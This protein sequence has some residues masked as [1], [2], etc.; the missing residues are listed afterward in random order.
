MT[1][2]RADTPRTAAG[3]EL[4]ASIEERNAFLRSPSEIR[5]VILAIEAEAA[6]EPAA[7]EPPRRRYG[8][9][10]WAATHEPAVDDFGNQYLARRAAQPP[11]GSLPDGVSERHTYIDPQIGPAYERHEYAGGSLTATEPLAAAI[12]RMLGRK[13]G[14]DQRF[15]S[16]DLAGLVRPHDLAD[17]ILQ[18]W[19]PSPPE[20]P[21]AKG[22][23]EI[24]HAIHDDSPRGVTPALDVASVARAVLD[25]FPNA[26][27]GQL[28]RIVARLGP[29]EDSDAE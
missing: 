17:A 29:P 6:A 14:E 18:E 21:I 4:L 12:K 27:A 26:T 25:E 10:A 2:Q 16:G 1:D 5:V 11:R 22:I 19:Q 23:R 7:A 3:R 8:N 28:D 20:N 24:R 15:D 9:A 13:P